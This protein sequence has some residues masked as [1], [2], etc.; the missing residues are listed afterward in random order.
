MD[1]TEIVVVGAGCVGANIAYRLAQQGAHVIVLEA[2]LPGGGTSGASFAWTN[3]FNKTPREYHALNVAGMEEHARLA[4]ELDGG[5]WLRQD[6]GLHWQERPPDQAALQETVRRLRSWSYPIEVLSPKEARELEPDLCFGPTVD[7]VVLAP[8]EGYVEVVPFIAAL[9][10]HAR[11]YGARLFPNYRVTALLQ[12]GHRIRGVVTEDSTKFEADIVVDCAGPAAD[13]IARLTGLEIPLNR[14]PGRLVYTTPAVTTLRRPVHAPGVHFRPDGGGRLVLA[15]SA[16]DVRWN[17]LAEP[18]PPER[19]LAAAVPHL[20]ALRGARVEAVRV[21]VRP[22]PADEKPMIGTL[23]GLEGFYVV[24]SHSGVT[25]GPLWGRVAAQEILGV[26]PDPRL[27]SYRPGRFLGEQPL[28]S[29]GLR[30]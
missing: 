19:S 7:E 17:A 11:R 13:E 22:M 28:R 20:P 18:W 27:A 29:V 2:G 9:L 3:A 6:G 23:P 21:G 24:V 5:P 12:D 14:V 16:H 15:E 8:R 4:E 1:R 10:G 30:S 25:L 26:R